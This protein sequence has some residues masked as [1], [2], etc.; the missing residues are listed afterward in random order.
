MPRIIRCSLI[1]AKNAELPESA[2]EI[3]KVMTDKHLA[4]IRQQAG[5]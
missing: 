3:K 1:Q 5:K 2:L 4:M